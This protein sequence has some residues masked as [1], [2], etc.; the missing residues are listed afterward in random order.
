MLLASSPETEL[1]IV[2]VSTLEASMH[3]ILPILGVLIVLFLLG[4]FIWQAVDEKQFPVVPSWCR[5]QWFLS[6]KRNYK[7]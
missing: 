3:Y 7:K 5:P 1:V 4:G 2:Y 6:L